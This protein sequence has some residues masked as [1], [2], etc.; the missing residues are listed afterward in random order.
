MG[1]Y[2]LCHGSVIIFH[3]HNQ[4]NQLIK[5]SA[6]EQHRFQSPCLNKIKITSGVIAWGKTQTCAG[7]GHALLFI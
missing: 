6:W 1:F 5:D 2:G 7:K 3:R 4:D